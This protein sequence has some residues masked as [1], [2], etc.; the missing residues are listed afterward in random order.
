MK[1]TKTPR[2]TYIKKQINLNLKKD[3]DI[4][5]I[6]GNINQII[7]N[8]KKKVVNDLNKISE[9][10]IKINKDIKVDNKKEENN[11]NNK[12]KDKKEK[13]KI[14]IYKKIIILK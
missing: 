1:K 2:R 10:N 4:E 12:I 14:L 11:F 13:L 9:S 7:N 6:L 8:S 5:N 3:E